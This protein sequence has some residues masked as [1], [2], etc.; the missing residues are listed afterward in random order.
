M[1]EEGFSKLINAGIGIK[2]NLPWLYLNPGLNSCSLFV[3]FDPLP[4]VVVGVIRALLEKRADFGRLVVGKVERFSS[5]PTAS[6]RLSAMCQN[7]GIL[8]GS[9]RRLGHRR[10]SVSRCLWGLWR[11]CL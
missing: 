4:C 3:G 10:G 9:V 1:T 8:K 7:V 2:T 11:R 5:T 6:R